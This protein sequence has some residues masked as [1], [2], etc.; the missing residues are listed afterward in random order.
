MKQALFEQQHQPQWQAFEAQLL[1]LEGKHKR[2]DP[3]LARQFCAHYSLV[4]HH[5]A[6]CQDRQ[7]SGGL[8][9]YLHHLAQRGHQALY[10]HQN[11]GLWA[12][13]WSFLRVDFPQ[14]VRQE[15]VLVYWAHALFYLP[16]FLALLLVALHP[17]MLAQ[18][19]GADVGAQAAQSY[20]DMAEQYAERVN[21]PAWQNGAMFG[22]YVFNNIGIAFQSFAGG[23]LFGIGSVYTTMYN[24]LII[25]GV[26]GYMVHEPSGTA[27]YSF[28]AAHGA[29]ELTGLVLAGAGG[30]RL[31]LAMLRPQGLSR[32][33][34]LKVQGRVAIRLMSGAF[35]LLAL[36][37]LVE[38]FWSPLTS[39]PMMLKFG[40]GFVM[41]SL[42]YAYLWRAG[43]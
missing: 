36:A 14:T 21:R 42:V 6:L 9:G 19:A 43:R 5:L 18:W 32:R 3:A 4:C 12:K 25:G 31:G 23:L 38:A 34:A 22:F 10:R 37:A 30:L 28:I 11:G 15:R 13:F 24:G 35:V 27:F 1:Q 39:I 2:M 26:M 40:V 8:A 41:W 16:L 29:F 33:D 17:P 20:A 7:Y